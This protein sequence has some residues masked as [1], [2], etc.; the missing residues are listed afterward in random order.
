MNFIGGLRQD[1]CGVG[2]HDRGVGLEE[3]H[4]IGRRLSPHLGGVGGVVLSDRDDLAREDRGQQS[5]IGERPAPA[6]ESGGAEGVLGDLL[7]D[8]GL[9]VP[10]DTDERN[11]IGTCHSTKTHGAE[12]IGPGSPPYRDAGGREV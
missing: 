5:H 10:L 4:R 6:G 11:T 3:D 1:D 9:L 12:S 2:A 7:R 8:P